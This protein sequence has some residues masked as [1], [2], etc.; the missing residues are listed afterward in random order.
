MKLATYVRLSARTPGVS[1]HDSDWPATPC[2]T[3]LPVR[4]STMSSSTKWP[5]KHESSSTIAMMS[6]ALPARS[7]SLSSRYFQCTLRRAAREGAKR[8]VS[9]EMSSE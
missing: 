6:A 1:F 4:G 3:S 2:A 5:S 8:K 9:T 7:S